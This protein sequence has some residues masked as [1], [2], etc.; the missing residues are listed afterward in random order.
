[1]KP[2]QGREPVFLS[3]SV[4]SIQPNCP[5]CHS[6][7]QECPICN[8][9]RYGAQ[10]SQARKKVWVRRKVPRLRKEDLADPEPGLDDE[11]RS[12][13]FEL[14]AQRDKLLIELELTR[15]KTQSLETELQQARGQ[16]Q[17]K[18]RALLQKNS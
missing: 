15:E 13:G 18:D 10:H 8:L 4:S 6:D 5:A 3:N 7:Q 17:S 14:E 1:M 9:N 12:L 2:Y 16:L 11:D